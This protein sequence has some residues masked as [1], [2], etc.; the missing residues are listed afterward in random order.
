MLSEANRLSVGEQVL[1][2]RGIPQSEAYGPAIA[3]G[4]FQ[5]CLQMAIPVLAS[6]FSLSAW[7]IGSEVAGYGNDHLG[8]PRMRRERGAHGLIDFFP[9]DF[10]RP[11][12]ELGLITQFRAVR[13]DPIGF[14]ATITS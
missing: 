9:V 1:N 6:G 14:D 3:R 5:P 10:A 12:V 2:R 8:H 4:K 7:N 11:E 13:L